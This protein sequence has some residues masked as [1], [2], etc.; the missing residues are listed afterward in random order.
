MKN[1]KV[2]LS[3]LALILGMSTAFA[4]LQ[5]KRFGI[6]KWTEDAGGAYSPVTGTK[7][8]DYLCSESANHC[9]ETYPDTV[10]PNTN[11]PLGEQGHVE[12]TSVELGDFQ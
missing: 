8:I 2:K 12:P 4:G 3:V 5:H 6:Q 1:L 11:P 7:G 10:N 9:T